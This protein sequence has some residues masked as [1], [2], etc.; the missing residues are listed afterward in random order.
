MKFRRD[1]QENVILAD[2]EDGRDEKY[3][4]AKS[5]RNNER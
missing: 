2:I 5:T 4:E 3:L 1:K